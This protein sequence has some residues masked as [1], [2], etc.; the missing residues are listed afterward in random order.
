MVVGFGRIAE[1][2]EAQDF[3]G[4]FIGELGWD[5]PISCRPVL[6]AV[7]VASKCGFVVYHCDDRGGGGLDVEGLDREIAKRSIERL[8]I[9]TVD[10]EQRWRWPERRKSGGTR[11]VVHEHRNGVA[12]LALFQRLAGIRFA[13]CEQDSLSV[14]TVRERVRAQFNADAVTS[15]FYDE[16]R[17]VQRSLMEAINGIGVDSERS[18]YSSLLLNRLMFIYFMQRKEFLNGDTDYL[19]TSLK[20]ICRLRGQDR[21]YEYYR[22]FLIPLFHD[23][24][25][26]EGKIHPD[27]KIAAIIGNVPYVNG[28]IFSVHPLEKKYNIRVADESF[29]QIFTFFDRYRWHLDERPTGDPNEINPEILGY[30]FEK[31]VNQKE[32]GAYY[33]KED[34]TGYMAAMTILPVA[35]GR[36][37]DTVDRSPWHLLQREPGRYIPE[38]LLY[39]CGLDLPVKVET[40]DLAEVGILDQSA[41]IREPDEPDVRLPGERWRETLARRETVADL[42]QRLAGGE[43]TSF[44]QAVTENLDFLTLALDW[45]G[46]LGGQGHAADVWAVLDDLKIIDPTCG[47]GA[48]LFAAFDIL[49]ELYTNTLTVAKKAVADQTANHETQQLT[50]EADQ[51]GSHAYFI[52]KQAVLANLY[53]VDLMPEATEIARLRLFLALV[54]RLNKRGDLEPLPDLDMNIRAGNVLVGCST[55][56]DAKCRFGGELLAMKRLEVMDK[57]AEKTA[58]V[59]RNFVNA[60]RNGDPADEIA[61]IKTEFQTMTAALRDELD[62]L[63]SP[64]DEAGTAHNNWRKSHQP[65]HWFVEFPEV[66]AGG[67]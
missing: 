1:L 14:L 17:K 31:Y 57:Q 63:Y 41:D 58:A 51:H 62:L 59:Y 49:E 8:L 65:F 29:Q 50:A 15:K 30:I 48:F 20:R 26:A 6:G 37:A 56:D 60:Q 25:G 52:A 55:A 27:E 53:G 19:A 42:R 2:V 46:E 10:G 40:A 36:I 66:M 44:T 3:E 45:I 24:L 9:V 21:F 12:N 47:S 28:G 23:G 67:G 61:A 4:L 11:Y 22:D 54:A 18:W 34:V 43:V 35:L 32:Q 7:P 64:H 16:F 5:N 39:G 33:T 38:G 13:L